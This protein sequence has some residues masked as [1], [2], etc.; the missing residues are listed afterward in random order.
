MMPNLRGVR[1]H[2]VDWGSEGSRLELLVDFQNAQGIPASAVSEGT[3]LTLGLLTLLLTDCPNVLLL[4]DIDRGLH[5][6]AQWELVGILRTML[7][8]HPELQILTT[9]H[10]PYLLDSLEVEEVWVTALDAD[11]A[12]HCR[13]LADHPRASELLDV[14]TTGELLSSQGEDWVLTADA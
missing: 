2:T 12:S 14:L 3:L 11:G 4:D 13:Q 8:R 9:S 10:S 6:K 1:V 7:N 5:P